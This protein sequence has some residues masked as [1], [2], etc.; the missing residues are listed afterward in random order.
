[1]HIFCRTVLQSQELYN[2]SSC[3]LEEMHAY[4]SA[5]EL[6]KPVACHGGVSRWR[7]YGSEGLVVKGIRYTHKCQFQ[8]TLSI[9]DTPGSYLQIHYSIN[10]SHVHY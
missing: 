2:N 3:S 6:I 8:I 4:L 7:M 9:K 5:G 10:V 1:M